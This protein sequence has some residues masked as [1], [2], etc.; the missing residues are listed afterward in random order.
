VKKFADNNS[1]LNKQCL[2]NFAAAGSYMVRTWYKQG[3]CKN[4]VVYAVTNRHFGLFFIARLI[5][6][7]AF[8]FR[9]HFMFKGSKRSS[10]PYNW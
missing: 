1:G 4:V 5:F 3:S 10:M 6:D 8:F 9:T 2:K 7:C